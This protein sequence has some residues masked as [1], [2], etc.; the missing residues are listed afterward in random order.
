MRYTDPEINTIVWLV[1]DDK[2][3]FRDAAARFHQLNPNRPARVLTLSVKWLE[4]YELRVAL[5]IDLSLDG[6]DQR[7]MKIMR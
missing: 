3:S 1:I 5:P 6:Q 2:M 4:K 7:Q